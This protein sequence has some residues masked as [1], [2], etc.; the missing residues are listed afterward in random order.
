MIGKKKSKKKAKEIDEELEEGKK[1]KKG[2]KKGK[3]KILLLIPIVLLA[4]AAA[5]FFLRGRGGTEEEKEKD[6]TVE[7][8]QVYTM[9][10][11]EILALPVIGEGVVVH[12][13]EAEEAAEGEDP[14]TAETYIYEGFVN[15]GELFA[16]YAGLL[17]AEDMGFVYVDD[18]M[19]VAQEP[20]FE[21]ESGSAILAKAAPEENMLLSVRLEW[22]AEQGTVIT[23]YPAGTIKQPRAET[24]S[25]VE[26]EDFLRAMEP[27]AL[28]L[29][30]DS[31]A[32]YRIYPLAGSVLVDG[33]PCIHVSVYSVD[34][35]SGANEVAGEYFIA[36]DQSHIYQRDTISGRV[37]E[38]G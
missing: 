33:R 1:G 8:P 5:V 28:G 30:G 3:R 27:S 15:V 20:D 10:E 2:K 6:D 7:P 32:E 29:T 17:T 4:A 16:G 35:A 14:I 9:G 34:E 26:A 23:D 19:T 11:N 25:L 13:P 22:T 36:A 24:L 21:E 18:T 37:S 31:M 38:V 12:H